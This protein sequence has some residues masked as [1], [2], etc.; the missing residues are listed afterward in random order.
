MLS[1]SLV[2]SIDG[3]LYQFRHSDPYAR[4]DFPQY[5]FKPL[6]GQRRKADLTLNRR[7]LTT[8]VYEVEGMQARNTEVEGNSVQMKLDFSN[9][10]SFQGL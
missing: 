4:T 5:V 1:K 7:Q 9:L 2:Y 3:Y 8:K 6:V 10:E